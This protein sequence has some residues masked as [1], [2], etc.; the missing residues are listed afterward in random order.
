MIVEPSERNCIIANMEHALAWFG[1]HPWK[2][3]TWYGICA[4]RC[5]LR[6]AIKGVLWS[7]FAGDKDDWGKN[8]EGVILPCRSCI[9]RFL[10]F[11]TLSSD[12][13]G[14]AAWMAI[15]ALATPGAWTLLVTRVK[16]LRIGEEIFENYYVKRRCIGLVWDPSLWQ[17]Q[18]RFHVFIIMTH[19]MFRSWVCSV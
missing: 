16:S 3:P 2:E 9:P 10:G 12:I 8:I 1:S 13:C 7:I 14:A 17:S 4:T 18:T 5:S 19:T 15:P 6:S 11:V